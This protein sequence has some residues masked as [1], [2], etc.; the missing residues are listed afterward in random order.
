LSIAPIPPGRLLGHS[1][2]HGGLG[3]PGVRLLE[4]AVV[5]GARVQPVRLGPRDG[6][7]QRGV[8]VAVAAVLGDV[9][10]IELPCRRCEL[11]VTAKQGPRRPAGN[12]RARSSE[13]VAVDVHAPVARVQ[14]A[15]L[16]KS[17][18]FHLL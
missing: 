12:D 4:R 2:D 10:K 3:A 6:E 1:R 8:P 5:R 18:G 17:G 7:P 9:H 13:N 11:A 16:C 14:R 15:E